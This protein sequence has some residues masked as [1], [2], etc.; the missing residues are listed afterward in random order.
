MNRCT[1]LHI[2]IKCPSVTEILPPSST[3]KRSPF[4][5]TVLSICNPL[6]SANKFIESQA[7][8]LIEAVLV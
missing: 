1:M 4:E 6:E 7:K 2:I 5:H 8:D 3:S